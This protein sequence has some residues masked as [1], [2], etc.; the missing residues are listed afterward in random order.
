MNNIHSV[1]EYFKDIEQNYAPYIS[2]TDKRTFNG[3]KSDIDTLFKLLGYNESE[4]E[5]N[6]SGN[7]VSFSED[8]DE[9]NY[10]YQY[11]VNNFEEPKF[12]NGF[13]LNTAL[14]NRA[15]YDEDPKIAAMGNVEYKVSNPHQL[16]HY[17]V[18]SPKKRFVMIT[19][20]NVMI[21]DVDVPED[22]VPDQY[23]VNGSYEVY[24]YKELDIND[25][26]TIYEKLK[27]TDFH[28]SLIDQT[29]YGNQEKLQDY[30]K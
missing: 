1:Y 19:N 22:T 20:I 18:G 10:R 21:V 3:F 16:N 29:K 8:V 12:E 9:T 26:E 15:G 17:F 23:E 6:V 14:C 30:S 27:N 2:D 4:F 13:A 25:V 7:T 5:Q 11:C 28:E 24:P